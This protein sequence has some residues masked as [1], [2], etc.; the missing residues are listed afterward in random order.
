MANFL[1]ELGGELF[2]GVEREDPVAGALGEGEVLLCGEAG[3]GALEDRGVE[4]ACD[5]KGAVGGAGVYDDDL[6]G[7]GYAGEGAREVLFF[8]EGDDRDGQERH[9]G[10]WRSLLRRPFSAS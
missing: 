6:V 1:L 9:R 2:V 4:A 7:P 3:P 8:V 10:R 5:F